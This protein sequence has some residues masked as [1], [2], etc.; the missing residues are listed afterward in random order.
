MPA[1]PPS[2]GFAFFVLKGTVGPGAPHY[3]LKLMP[4]SSPGFYTPALP[5]TT[6]RGRV[7]FVLDLIGVLGVLVG[8]KP[9][10]RR[11]A[12]IARRS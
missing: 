2:V 1:S 10:S 11:A 12:A 8:G 7:T 5:L 9:S 3:A 6:A 4:P